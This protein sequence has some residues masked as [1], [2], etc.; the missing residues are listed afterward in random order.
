MLPPAAGNLPA[1]LL[2]ADLALFQGRA[3]EAIACCSRW[4]RA[5][6][7]DPQAS[8]LAGRALL[9]AG[10]TR[11]SPRIA[12][13]QRAAAR[14]PGHLELAC[15]RRPTRPAWT[16]T[17]TPPCACSM[18]PARRTARQQ[19]EAWFGLGRVQ[20]EK[21]NL[22]EARRALDEAIRL[23]PDAP[24]Y[25]GERATLEALSGDSAG[26]PRRASSRPWPASP[27]TTWPGPAWASCSSRSARPRR[28]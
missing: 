12:A 5:A 20:G 28:R 25:L 13:G 3:D 9:I 2:R 1:S 26:G 21:D 18:P 11:R 15:W 17:A 22:A 19:H 8:A 27:T 23:A 10:R 6:H 14:H 4:H 16:A 24:G 7:G